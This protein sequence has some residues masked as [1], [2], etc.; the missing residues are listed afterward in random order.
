MKMKIE[1]KKQL[2]PCVVL[3]ANG[4][5]YMELIK[6]EMKGR[7]IDKLW[8]MVEPYIHVDEDYFNVK[9]DLN[10]DEMAERAVTFNDG[11]P[12]MGERVYL[13]IV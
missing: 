4:N 13:K 3:S 11:V 7:I 2:D 10:V 5:H 1:I 12:Q 9:M 8:E 6:D